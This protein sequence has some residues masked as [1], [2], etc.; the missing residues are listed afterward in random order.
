MDVPI[1]RAGPLEDDAGLVVCLRK[2][3][4]Q[5]IDGT[6]LA[7]FEWWCGLPAG[8]WQLCR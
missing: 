5:W 6:L 2:R 1:V 7:V 8:P 4:G 3:D